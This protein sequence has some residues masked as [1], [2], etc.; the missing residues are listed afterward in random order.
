[1]NILAASTSASSEGTGRKSPTSRCFSMSLRTS[2]CWGCRFI[3]RT[4]IT[5]NYL[6]KQARLDSRS[7]SLIK[8]PFPEIHKNCFC[9]FIAVS[10]LY[11]LLS[12]YLNKSARRETNLSHS[13]SKSVNLKRNLFVINITSIALAGYFFVRHNDRCEDGSELNNF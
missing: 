4:I 2:R 1:M 7:R 12:Y 13:E 6:L 5:V 3:H 10:E 9:T 8:L 11:M